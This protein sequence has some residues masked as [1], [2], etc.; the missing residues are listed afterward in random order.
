MLKIDIAPEVGALRKEFAHLTPKQFGQALSRA[1]NHVGAKARTEAARDV[2][3]VYNIPANQ[4]KKDITLIRSNQKTLSAKLHSA[5]KPVPMQSFSPRQTRKGV[6]VKIGGTREL[7]RSAFMLTL[8]GG[9]TGVFARGRYVGTF[10]FRKERK[11]GAKKDLP[12]N[13]LF[14]KSVP[15]A[16]VNESIMTS[17]R[18]RVASDLPQRVR[19][20]VGFLMNRIKGQG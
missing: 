15:R 17:I 9:H 6:S 19:H 5:G 4:I 11:P 3:K 20:E 18:G 8:K 13:E 10:Q 1:L 16:L 7:L 14:S 2:R 12:I